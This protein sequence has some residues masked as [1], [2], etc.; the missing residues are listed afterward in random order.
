MKKF[1]LL[2]AV[3]GFYFVSFGQAKKPTIMIVPSDNWCFQNGFLL[4]NNNQ[5]VRVRVPDYKRALIEN[6][7]L[8][9]VISTIN[10]LMAERG[11]PLENLESVIKTLEDEALENQT[12][13]SKSG[14]AI[15][16]SITDKLKA[17]AKAD[18]IIQLGW[19]LSKSGFNKSVTFNLQGLDAYT[20]KQ[21]ATGVGT[22]EP[23]SSADINVLLREA[24]LAHIDNFNASLM[25]H[26]TD[27]FDNGRE[28]VIRVKK[29]DS[30]EDD[31]ETEFNDKELLEY[32]EEWM[33]KNT[34]KGR[35]NIT[36]SSADMMVMKQV[37]IPMFDAN[38]NAIDANSFAR[39]L[40]KYL[41]N[42]PFGI[43]NKLE[44]NGLGGATIIL[45]SK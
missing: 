39:G 16:E 35:F 29:F 15:S 6:S 13:T 21:I 11:F 10:G 23:S 34:V 28:V 8:L 4:E 30:W 17:K 27:L 7:E 37:R 32:I 12:L 41:K 19:T 42:A 38:G 9:T 20:N 22:G 31:L 24:V 3:L 14:A 36:D 25:T 45:G 1:L 2:F 18:I 26:F 43:V 44:R 40:S 5:G 33:Q